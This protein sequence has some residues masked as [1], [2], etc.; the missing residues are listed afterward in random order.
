MPNIYNISGLSYTVRENPEWFAGALFGSRLIKGGYIRP[1]TGIKGDELLSQISLEGNILQ[2]DNNDCSWTPQQI[3]RLSEKTANVRTYKINLE[4]CIDEL[5][6]K[7]T[8][9]Q[10]SPGAANR[11]LP[12]DLESATMALLADELATNIEEMIVG[13]NHT[14]NSNE[15]NGIVQTLKLST[16]SIQVALTG[17]F[18]VN[19]IIANFTKVYD[20]IPERVL[21]KEDDGTLFLLVSY[22]TRRILRHAIAALGTEVLG[23]EWSLDDSDK[24]NPRMF[25]QGVEIVPVKKIDDGSIIAYHRDNVLFLT[26]L[27]SDL[28]E[29]EL[30]QFAPPSDNKVFIRGRLRLGVAIPFEDECVF[31]STSVTTDRLETEDPMQLSTNSVL[32]NSTDTAAKTVVIRVA[33]GQ[34]VTAKVGPEDDFH[35]EAT[36]TEQTEGSGVYL[37]SITPEDRTLSREPTWGVVRLHI[38]GTQIFKDVVIDQRNY[39]NSTNDL[40]ALIREGKISLADLGVKRELTVRKGLEAAATVQADAA[41]RD[42]LSQAVLEAERARQEILK[43]EGEKEALQWHV[44]FLSVE[45]PEKINMLETRLKNTQDEKIKA[46]LQK[47]LDALLSNKPK[48]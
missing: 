8:I 9:Y 41:L 1:L 4:Q 13:G 23:I 34:E 14:I 3:V 29:L 5:E 28:E 30:G 38:T 15:F 11:E 19:N 44:K 27:L 46:S 12:D 32:F 26:D 48:K 2:G 40:Q 33:A 7:R 25:Y 42:T 17:P 37:L 35:F 24:K 31:G 20:A 45:T 10:L 43:L 21:Q 39:D 47:Q 22:K 6:Q 18:T 36:L 16:E